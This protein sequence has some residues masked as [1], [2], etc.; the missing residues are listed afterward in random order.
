[1][2]QC[3]A[4]RQTKPAG[5]TLIELLVVIAIIAI[6]AA[7]LLPALAAAKRKAYVANCVSNQKQTSLALQMYFNDFNDRCPPGSGARSTPGP[8]V[9]YGLTDGQVPVYNGA[10]SGNC[11][12]WLPIYIQPYL[13]GPDPKF[14]GIVSNY[15]VKVFV[16]P[17][18][19]SIWAIGTIDSASSLTDPSVDNY[20]SYNSSSNPNNG[21][22]MGS[23]SLNLAADN[24]PNGILLNTAFPSGNTLGS[25]KSQAGP[26]PFGEG[27]SSEEPLNLRQIAGAGVSLSSLWSMADADE[28]ASGALVKPGC[29]LK[30][31]HKTVRSYAYFDGHAATG[32]VNYNSQ[33]NGQYDQ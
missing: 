29:A 16:C 25:N 6:L 28:V 11:M 26:Q 14:V 17:A 9:N 33:Y 13:G 8:G 4:R 15:V 7:M 2:L 24:T 21:N 27:A 22:T 10:T 1:M 5:F 18:Y 20:Q 19:T 12:K 3:P 31:V 32:K 23:Y 30:P